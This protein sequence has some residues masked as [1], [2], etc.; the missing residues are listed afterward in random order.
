VNKKL[1]KKL[2][3]K[4][5]DLYVCK[6]AIEWLSSQ[7]TLEE[8]WKNCERGDWLLWLI[9]MLDVDE[10]RLFL[11]KGLIVNKIIHLMTDERSIA[12][13]TAA[14]DYGRNK[15]DKSEL[16]K[17]AYNAAEAAYIADNTIAAID[18]NTA[19]YIAAAAANAAL[20]AAAAAAGSDAATNAAIAYAA[21]SRDN[22]EKLFLKKSANIVR[23]IF[24]FDDI[25]NSFNG[26]I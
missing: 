6:E 3:N 25:E 2:I 9:A 20:A 21:A 24:N 16:E 8:A 15:I 10:K 7:T 17:A 19:A 13:C 4:L 12:A 14:I 23:E 26:K 1:I 11:A 22:N 5:N 18:I